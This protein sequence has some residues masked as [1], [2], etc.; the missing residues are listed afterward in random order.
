VSSKGGDSS[1]VHGGSRMDKLKVACIF[2][3]VEIVKYVSNMCTVR[4]QLDLSCNLVG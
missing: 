4:L 3:K 1:L 2:A